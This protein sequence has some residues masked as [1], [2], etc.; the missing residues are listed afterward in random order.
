MEDMPMKDHRIVAIFTA[1]LILGS[2]ACI[3]PV[4]V[5]DAGRYS[6]PGPLMFEKTVPLD[7]GGSIAVE[8]P[9]GD[10]EVFGWDR[11]EVQ[12][13]AEAGWDWRRERRI[14]VYGPGGDIP[15]VDVEKVGDVLRIKLR[16][17]GREDE[18]AR[19]VRIILNVPRPV[20]LREVIVRRGR[21]TIGDIYG[22]ARL[23]IDDGDVRVE[24]YSGS[25]DV[26]V[27]RGSVEA[28]ILDLR[29]EDVVRLVS[30]QGPVTLFLEPGVS[31][32]IEAEAPNG[33]ITSDFDLGP[34]ASGKKK[35]GATTVGRGEGGSIALTAS[36]GDVRLRKV[37]K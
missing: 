10:V 22:K 36:N 24:N 25:L 9:V 8:N 23:S 37:V 5:D 11:N 13:S 7:R 29:P 2:A 15:E 26:S 34:A 28:E 32:R 12:V 21:I 6:R 31:A 3:I 4:Y 27:E 18:G 20:A 30:R 14:N 33:R 35:V 16:T 19:P 17:E 1:A